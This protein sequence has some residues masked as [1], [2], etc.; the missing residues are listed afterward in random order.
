MQLAASLGLRVVFRDDLPRRFLGFS[1]PGEDKL[2]VRPSGY[3]PRD[4]Q[5]I[6]HEIVECHLPERLPR[7][8]EEFCQRAGAAMLLPREAFIS[9]LFDARIDLPTM[10]R[11]WTHASY[12]VIGRRVEDLF[13]GARCYTWTDKG[14]CC[15]E[16]PVD[17]ELAAIHVACS[18]RRGRS[19]LESDGMLAAAWHLTR[20]A[21][22]TAGFRAIS[23]LMPAA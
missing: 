19:V 8:H 15:G 14:P 1:S 20:R 6:C 7:W 5:T 13:P 17:V 11:Q 4:A 21:G 2:L 9:S 16:R 3:W 18:M 10:R 23:L 12:E 22:D